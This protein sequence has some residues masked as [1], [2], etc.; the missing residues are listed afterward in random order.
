MSAKDSGVLT[1]GH[2]ILECYFDGINYD[3]I[4]RKNRAFSEYRA[5]IKVKQ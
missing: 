4:V 5:N 2:L 1:F 3:S